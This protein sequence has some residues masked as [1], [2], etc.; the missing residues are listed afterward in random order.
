MTHEYKHL[1][2]DGFESKWGQQREEIPGKEIKGI[3]WSEQYKEEDDYWEKKQENYTEYA[4]PLVDDIELAIETV[5]EAPRIL[6]S[7]LTEFTNN[8]NYL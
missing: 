4:K 7:G 6:R 3:K 5:L 1:R 8:R 2:N